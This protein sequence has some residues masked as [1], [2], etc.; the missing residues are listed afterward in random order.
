[1]TAI[2]R[3]VTLVPPH[4]VKDFLAGLK[5]RGGAPAEVALKEKLGKMLA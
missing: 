2:L 1:V 5:K 3:E 4:A